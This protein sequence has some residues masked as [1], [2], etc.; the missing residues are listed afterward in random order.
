MLKTNMMTV[1]RVRGNKI[2]DAQDRYV[3]SYKG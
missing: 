3:D 2:E 1:I